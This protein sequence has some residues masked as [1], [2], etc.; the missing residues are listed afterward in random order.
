MYIY[1]NKYVYNMII[2]ISDKKQK[3]TPHK[4]KQCWLLVK[5][6][7]LM[8]YSKQINEYEMKIYRNTVPQRVNSIKIN[9]Y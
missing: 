9:V 8:D 6:G 1:K 4:I 2:K 7:K 3:P 5:N